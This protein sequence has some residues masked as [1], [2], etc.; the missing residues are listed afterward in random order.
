MATD[1]SEDVIELHGEDVQQQDW[2]IIPVVRHV[3]KIAERASE[4]SEPKHTQANALD[5]AFRLIGDQAA[6]G[7]HRHDQWEQ[8]N[9]EAVPIIQRGKRDEENPDRH[10]ETDGS[11]SKQSGNAGV[12]AITK[13]T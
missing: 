9:K 10:D 1:V 2:P 7:N 4:E 6:G 5:I 12:L 8:R 13:K 3:A 11:F